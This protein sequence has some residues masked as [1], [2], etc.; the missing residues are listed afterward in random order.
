[1]VQN[2]LVSAD[3]V[4]REDSLGRA[5]FARQIVKSLKTF[6][7]DQRDSL[8]VGISGKWGSGKST[9]L[10]FIKAE[11]DVVHAARTDGYKVLSFN[12][13]GHTAGDDL[14]RGFLKAVVDSVSKLDWKD[15]AVGANDK[16]KKYLKYLDYVKFAGNFHPVIKSL[17]DGAKEYSEE[18]DVVSLEEIRLEANGLL[19][20]TG[21]RLY[22]LID[23]LDRLTPVEITT[24]FRILKV[25]LNL[26][27]TIFMVAYDK[28]VVVQALENQYGFDGEKYLEKIIQV[29]FNIPQ[30]S[31]LQ[32][33]GLFFD[34]MAF[35]PVWRLHGLKE[36]FR[37]VRDLNR[38]F[39][40]LIF[41]LPN[42]VGEVNLFDFLIL[43]A[44]RTFDGEAYHR[45]Y[46]HII[47]ILRKGVWEGISLDDRFVSTYENETTRAL[48]SYL[49]IRRYTQDSDKDVKRL[50]D[51][52]YFERYFS[53]SVIPGTIS[54]EQL[55]HFFLKEINKV[56]V[57]ASALSTG[58]IRGL[59]ARLSDEKLAESHI[60]EGRN[61][62][63]DFIDFFKT[64]VDPEDEELGV[65]IVKSYFNL[66]RLF[67]D[68]YG[69]A[70]AAIANLKLEKDQGNRI[71]FMFKHFM[72][73]EKALVNLPEQVFDQL[74]IDMVQQAENLNIYL[75]GQV[76]QTVFR[77]ASDEGSWLEN[78]FILDLML[79]D[80]DGYLRLL[81]ERKSVKIIW[82]IVSH[83]LIK[84]EPDGNLS[85][86]W[87]NVKLFFP[88]E[89]LGGVL[90]EIA[91][92]YPGEL[93][94]T[95]HGEL[96]FFGQAF[97]INE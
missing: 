91:D 73:K 32:I 28:Q 41:S 89:V 37:S 6:F 74:K 18:V 71:G 42:I 49:F 30:V 20:D 63:R 76:N 87:E 61:V 21:I 16:F 50:R 95:E 97:A 10:E 44:V 51:R 78:L 85:V 31:Q 67:Q 3:A 88:E 39:N 43:D 86:I 29:D 94:D 90:A 19:E 64:R 46:G 59:L 96:C 93:R 56:V 84:K 81:A 17:L 58:K 83:N 80:H 25:N 33:E 4:A 79:V 1:M 57:L 68:S 52:D 69:A 36:Y 60:L 55:E 38:Y 15:K 77:I 11:L 70:S 9:L 34:W 12:S 26:S 47:E 27:N 53:L 75:R 8:V 5:A 45:L 40:N 72:L 62:F 35:R 54:D 82:F 66:V 65:L 48:F 14:E 2:N 24:L 23:D 13:W 92:I 22:I 7:G